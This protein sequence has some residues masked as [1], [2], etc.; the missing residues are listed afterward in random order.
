[1]GPL[2]LP[3]IQ[4]GAGLVQ[5]IFG[6][7]RA[8]KAQKELERTQAPS[9]SPSKAISDY[10][11][12]A[13]SRYGLSPYE[14][15][16]YK[17]QMQNIQRS[18]A[19]GLSTM[20]EG[21]TGIGGVAALV[22]AQ[23]DA[24]LKAAG[25][26]EQEQGSRLNQLGQASGMMG[27]EHRQMFNINQ[28]LPYQQKVNLLSQK[29]AGGAAT[30]NAGLQNIFGGLSSMGQLGLMREFNK[31]PTYETEDDYYPD[32]NLRPSTYRVPLAK[33]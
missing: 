12:K 30:T 32:S 27:D 5:S 8:R 16:L 24:M 26:A 18:T 4:A 15:S 21:R 29:A 1:M 6:G 7:I 31:Q 23:N 9:Y 11:N 19:Q 3:A 28:M 22:Q 10:Y 25:A 33:I 2:V 14:S 20:Q 13:L 17:N